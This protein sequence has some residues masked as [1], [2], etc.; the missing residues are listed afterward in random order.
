M[1]I[2]LYY[3]KFPLFKYIK[4]KN[5]SNYYINIFYDYLEL[6]SA[7]NYIFLL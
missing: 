5:Y 7:P 6:I 3:K 4:V 1:M 2:I